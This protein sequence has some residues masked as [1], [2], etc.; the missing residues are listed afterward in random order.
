MVAESECEPLENPGKVCVSPGAD[1]TFQMLAAPLT[2]L[3][4]GRGYELVTP[5]AKEGGSDMFAEPAGNGE[6]Q[7]DQNNGVPAEDGEGFLLETRS[8][9]GSF[10]GAV[11]SSYV[12]KRD[13]QAGKWSYS[14]LASP[15]LGVQVPS[16]AVF[17]ADMS[18]VAFNDALG[19]SV[20][21]EGEH[22]ADLIG[23][24]GGPYTI[25]NSEEQNFHHGDAKR[26]ETTV[27]GAS[28][29]LK[30]VI[31]ESNRDSACGPEGVSGKVEEGTILCEWDGGLGEN[32][33]PELSLL[34]F[35]PASQSKPASTCGAVLGAA[36]TQGGGEGGVPTES[37]SAYR[38]VSAD[39]SRVFFTAPAWEESRF[40]AG[41]PTDLSGPGCWNRQEE[42]EGKPPV[43]APQLYARVTQDV[44][45][46]VLHETLR[47]S[48][49]ANGVL[50]KGTLR[51]NIRRC[52]SVPPK[53]ARRCSSSR[54]QS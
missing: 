8:A 19:A 54:K 14:S 15:S 18:L 26:V 10:P 3:P 53:T 47:V 33:L 32:G 9:F 49:P 20:G 44:A 7:D 21:E 45:G 2:G 17:N 36:G 27:V 30:H 29:D 25:L 16:D 46:E 48:A 6:F 35:V 23:A 4:D 28:S 11:R 13:Y 42:K 52:M 38:A 39:G 40:V 34:N 12:F 37:G 41:S 31:L 5:A 50:K 24:P 22:P 51:G 43:H 1:A